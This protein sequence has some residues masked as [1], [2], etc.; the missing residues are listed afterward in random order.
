MGKRAERGAMMER[1]AV[2]ENPLVESE[3]PFKK[4]P[5]LPWQQAADKFIPPTFQFTCCG[6]IY[7]ATT[8]RELMIMHEMHIARHPVSL[9]GVAG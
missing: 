1:D 9:Q 5:L 8:K 4:R 3:P 7:R 6:V 2:F